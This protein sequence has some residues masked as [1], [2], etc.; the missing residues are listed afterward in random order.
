MV[1]PKCG[2]ES[3]GRFCARCGSPLDVAPPSSQPQHQ[4]PAGYPQHQ[5]GG[6][7]PPPPQYGQPQQGPPPPQNPG[8]APPPPGYGPPPGYQQP[9]PGGQYQQPPP[10]GQ[11]Q[12]PP[13]GGQYQQGYPQQ[14]YAPPPQA[15][16]SGLS[17][18]AASA[19]CYALHILTGV[20][21][22][23]LEPYNRNKN[24]RFHAFQSIFFGISVFVCLIGVSL[25]G[26]LI[27]F[28]PYVGWILSLVMWTLIPLGF[29]V[30]WVMLMYKAYNNERW[31][32]PLIGPLAEKQ[33]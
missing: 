14:G 31:V 3:Q 20:L 32:L 11:Y 26:T 19:L 12:Q 29:F 30:V 5:P 18:N 10:G 6:Y 16:S 22:L 4:A 2:S 1:C 27:A 21:F 28:L 8:Y 24:I 15:G 17:D 13:P 25:V 7:A 9:P 33:A 23:V